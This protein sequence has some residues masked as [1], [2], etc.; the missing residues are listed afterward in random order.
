MGTAKCSVC[1]RMYS[2]DG[3]LGDSDKGIRFMASMVKK[4]ICPDCKRAG[5]T[6]GGG[7]NASATRESEANAK[8]AEA[9]ARAIEKQAAAAAKA[10]EMAADAAFAST[11]SNFTFSGE[12]EEIAKDFES[13]YQY[14]LKKDLK[15]DQKKV[16][17]DKL[18]L[19]LMALKKADSMKGD[20]YEKKVKEEKKKRKIMKI[21]KIVG[22]TVGII[23]LLLLM[24]G[25]AN[26]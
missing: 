19:G 12:P 1:G 21:V 4:P 17:A 24:I 10:Q 23:A 25:L 14:W 2:Q 9:Q 20:F 7:G 16:V 26:Q 8:L 5:L 6:A 18:E 13:V 11:M 15:K 22:W 3:L